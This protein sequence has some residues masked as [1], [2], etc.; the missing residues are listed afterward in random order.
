MKRLALLLLCLALTGCVSAPSARGSRLLPWNWFSS[1][2]TAALARAQVRNDDAKDDLREL[3]QQYLAAAR[4]ALDLEKARQL[5]AGGTVSGEV[6][7]AADMTTRAG[8]ALDKSEGALDPQK[9]RDAE[10]MVARLTSQ[11]AD[12]RKLGAA[13]LVTMDKALNLASTALN[14]SDEKLDSLQTQIGQEQ[15]RALDAEAKYHKLWFIVWCVVGGW[16]FL[17]FLPLLSA[18]FPALA[19]A[20]RIAGMVVAPAVQAGANRI[21]AAAGAGIHAVERLSAS[22]A[23]ALR[24]ELDG[25]LTLADQREVATAYVTSAGTAAKSSA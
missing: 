13:N 11:L 3:A 19:P 20:A 10:A 24:A 1:D 4:A 14:K 23:T 15:Q 8:N 22:A 21:K 12:E 5:S 6:S 18:I 25:P 9:L 2:S 17:Q 7:T 16:A